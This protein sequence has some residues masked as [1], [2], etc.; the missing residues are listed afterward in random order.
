L[1]IQ[2]SVNFAIVEDSNWLFVPVMLKYY[3]ADKLNIA[4]GPQGT[5]SLE[6]TEGLVSTFGLD[7]AFGAGYDINDNFYLQ[8]RYAL[9]LTNRTPDISS[10]VGQGLDPDIIGD[11][12]IKTSINSFHIGVGCRFN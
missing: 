9:E 12:D 7:L 8:A 10:F 1:F 6:D 3:V 4:A 11:I 5:F 2:P